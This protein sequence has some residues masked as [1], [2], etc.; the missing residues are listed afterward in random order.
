MSEVPLYATPRSPQTEP[1]SLLL[2][3]ASG[4][5]P[6]VRVPAGAQNVQR[7]LPGSPLK[8]AS[9]NLKLA[10]LRVLSVA[11]QLKPARRGLAASFLARHVECVR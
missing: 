9:L 2:A 11:S 6:T 1:C 3:F 8:A 10:R 5:F 7:N 4:Q